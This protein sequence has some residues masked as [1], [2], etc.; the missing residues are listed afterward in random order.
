ML[1]GS[2]F[3]VLILFVAVLVAVAE[4]TAHSKD[5][6]FFSGI[7]FGFLIERDL[8]E[9]EIEVQTVFLCMVSTYIWKL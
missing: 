5:Y 6:D 9:G 1:V 3:S 4:V 7:G 2:I 8:V